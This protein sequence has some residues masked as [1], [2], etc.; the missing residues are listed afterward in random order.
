[1]STNAAQPGTMKAIEISQPGAPE[2]LVVTERPMPV[3]QAGEL[4][5]KI[6]AA[7]VNRPDVLQRQGTMRHRPAL[8]ISPAR[9]SP[10]K[11]SPS[12]KA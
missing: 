1:M 12:V 7:G 2:V 5:V 6:A 3:P 9:K 10:A 8:R 4:T 11:S